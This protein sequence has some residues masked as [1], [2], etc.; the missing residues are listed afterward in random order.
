[1]RIHFTTADLARTGLANGPDSMWE[2]VNS[3]QML[4]SRYGRAVFDPWRRRTVETLRQADL[5]GRVRA[6]LFPIAPH[7]A[8]FPDLLTPSEGALGVNEGIEAILR[9]PRH[10]LDAELG[11]LTRTPGAASWVDDLATG[12]VAALTELGQVLRT[13]HETAVQPYWSRLSHWVDNDL[14]IRR[15]AIRKGGVDL[16]LASFR[17]MMR[18]N[19]PVLEVPGHPSDR[20]IHLDGRGIQLIPSYFCWLHPLTIFDPG[21]PQVVVYPVDHDLRWLEPGIAGVSN[22]RLARLLGH[23]RAEVLL[24][25]RD[26]CTTGDLARRL[27]VSA[28]VISHH[29]G[30]LR[31]SGLITSRRMANNVLHA[32]SPLGSALCVAHL[33]NIS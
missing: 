19:P 22:R 9:T 16:L 2:L 6:R 18:W 30:I 23:T 31:D 4:Q 3:L 1:M 21:L 11:L 13:F 28:A 33:D 5:T 20:D 27:G 15:Q 25:A 7:A 26:G 32:R 12:R 24:A 10:R 17:P 8:Y 29:T 14:A